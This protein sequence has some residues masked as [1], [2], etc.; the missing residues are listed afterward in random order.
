MPRSAIIVQIFVSS[1]SDVK[2]ERDILESVV[3]E[4][5]KIWSKSVGVSFE[6]YAGKLIHISISER[7]LRA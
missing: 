6:L 1:P 2:E 4:L 5:N 7:I 3:R